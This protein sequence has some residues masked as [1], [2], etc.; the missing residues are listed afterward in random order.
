MQ[1]NELFSQL[2][3]GLKEVLKSP[4]ELQPR[5]IKSLSRLIEQNL[6]VD[7]EW[8]DFKLHFEHVHQH[9][10]TRLK[11]ACPELSSAEL[12]LCAL[13]RL[14]LN[15]K[16]SASILGISPTSVK[17]ARYRLRKKLNLNQEASIMDY[18]LHLE[19]GI[20]QS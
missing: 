16:E 12:K 7:K 2:Q 10:F 1:K 6:Q 8:E 13:I 19:S 11:E 17:T 15:M 3:E 14:N 4:V 5:K 9:F 20:S 18:L